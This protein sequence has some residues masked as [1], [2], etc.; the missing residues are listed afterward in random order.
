M[1]GRSSPS[2]FRT[3]A[4]SAPTRKTSS[5]STWRRRRARAIVGLAGSDTRALTALIREKGMP[6]AVI[7]H[8]ADGKFDTAALKKEA[9]GWPGLVGMDLVPMVT[10]AQRLV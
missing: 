9:A 2:L 7:A 3:S 5:R 10:S 6:N 1:P 8:A 4:M